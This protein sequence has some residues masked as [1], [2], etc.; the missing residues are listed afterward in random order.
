MFSVNFVKFLR[1]TFLQNTS[2]RLPLHYFEI[3]R[4]VLQEFEHLFYVFH[5][6]Q[7]Y[8]WRWIRRK[9]FCFISMVL[10]EH[11]SVNLYVF[12]SFKIVQ[13]PFFANIDLWNDKMNFYWSSKK[14]FWIYTMTPKTLGYWNLFTEKSFHGKTLKDTMKAYFCYRHTLF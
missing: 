13:L 4:I 5:A 6:I 2:G 14:Y 7:L 3:K 12:Y 1:T 10:R 9:S 8:R 11:F